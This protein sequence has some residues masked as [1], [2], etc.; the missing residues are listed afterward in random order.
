MALLSGPSAAA[1][2]VTLYVDNVAGTQTSGCT[3]PGT[4][5]CKTFGDG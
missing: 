2:S 4:G 3:N 1:A 5:A